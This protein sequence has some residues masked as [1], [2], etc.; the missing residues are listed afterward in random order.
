MNTENVTEQLEHIQQDLRGTCNIC[1]QEATFS[2]TDPLLYRE[3]LFCSVCN[4]TSRYRSLARG[5][6][7]AINELTGLQARSLEE[8]RSFEPGKSLSVYDTQFHFTIPIARIRFLIRCFVAGGLI[9]I[10]RPI[11]EAK[12]WASN[13]RQTPL[14]KTWKS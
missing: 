3:S 14:T 8:L 6:L 4:T 13:W 12:R 1:G 7:R 5:V 10:F 9:C 2:G 11:A